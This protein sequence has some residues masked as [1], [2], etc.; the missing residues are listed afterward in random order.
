MYY[1][2]ITVQYYVADS[3]I[4]TL[5]DDQIGLTNPLLEWNSFVHRGL[6]VYDINLIDVNVPGSS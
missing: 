2:A 5:L 4:L 1:K 3:V 6:M